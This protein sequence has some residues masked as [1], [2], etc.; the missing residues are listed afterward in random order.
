MDNIAAN[1]IFALEVLK[2]HGVILTTNP[3]LVNPLMDYLRAKG[4]AYTV[5]YHNERHS[6]V[7]RLVGEE[8]ATR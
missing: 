1:V 6:F 7:F 5:E 3:E 8:E 4:L 2:K